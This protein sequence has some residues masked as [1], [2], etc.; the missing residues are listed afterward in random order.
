[1]KTSSNVA[2]GLAIVLSIVEARALGGDP[3]PLAPLPS[4][5]SESIS[6]TPQGPRGS[7]EPPA[8]SD[9]YSEP[10]VAEDTDAAQEA[11]VSLPDPWSEKPFVIEGELGLGTPVGFLG[12]ALD[13]SPCPLIGL[14]LGV[15]LGTAGLQY[16]FTPRVRLFRAGKRTFTAMYLGVG[17]SAGRFYEP[18]LSLTDFISV[19]G[20]QGH[21]GAQPLRYRWDTAYWANF[22]IGVEVRRP[23]RLSL[24]PYAGLSVLVNPTTSSMDL[25]YLGAG[26]R[27]SVQRL[28]PYVG[29]AFGYPL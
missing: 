23:S 12:V 13:Y 17:A 5:P 1:M 18:G 10:G 3:V 2:R 14:N 28:S 24:R 26:P 9:A 7:A 22:E 25:D 6:S 21:P 4:S 11:K 27:S 29:F 8:P 19:D 16:A 15:G 20:S